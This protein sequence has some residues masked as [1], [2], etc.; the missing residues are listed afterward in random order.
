MN[1]EALGAIGEIVG[2][3]AVIVTLRYLAVQIRG[4]MRIRAAGFELATS[5]RFPARLA[6]EGLHLSIRIKGE[7][8]FSACPIRG[9]TARHVRVQPIGIEPSSLRTLQ[10]G[11]RAR[12]ESTG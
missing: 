6:W 3:V 11:R 9:S 1:W 10:C 12:S 2:A 8:E 4:G 5:R 7:G